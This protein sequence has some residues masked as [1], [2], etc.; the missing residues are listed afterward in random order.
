MNMDTPCVSVCVLDDTTGYC[1][2]CGRS[3]R[4]IASWSD[5]PGEQRGAISGVLPARLRKMTS[6]SVRGARRRRIAP[7]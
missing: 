1:I 3:L 4:E 6:R 5:L 7:A 2:G